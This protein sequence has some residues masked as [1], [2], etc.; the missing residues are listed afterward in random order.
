MNEDCLSHVKDRHND[1]QREMR[2]VLDKHKVVYLKRKEDIS[3]ILVKY[4][5]KYECD[6]LDWRKMTM[7][8]VCVTDHNVLI[9]W[10]RRRG[11]PK[12]PKGDPEIPSDYREL[13]NR[14]ITDVRT[15]GIS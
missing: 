12:V 1:K 8:N 5:T 14:L 3:T 10:L 6:L 13:T 11:D 4:N 7:S 9:G 15:K 2:A